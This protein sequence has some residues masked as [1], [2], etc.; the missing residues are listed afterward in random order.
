MRRPV[1]GVLLLQPQPVFYVTERRISANIPRHHHAHAP[2]NLP[3][4]PPHAAL[5]RSSRLLTLHTAQSS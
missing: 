1:T 3:P 4:L 5:Q 2:A